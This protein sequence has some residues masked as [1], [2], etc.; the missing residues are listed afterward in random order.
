M[1]N[2]PHNLWAEIK[3]VFFE[4]FPEEAV[5]AIWG[6]KWRK[7][8]NIHPEPMFKFRISDGDRA[9]LLSNPPSLFLHSHP[10][11]SAEPSDQ[12]TLS[13]LATGWNWGIVAVKGNANG[14][15]YSV[16]YPECWGD[17][18]TPPPLLGRTFLWGVRDCWTLCRDWYAEQG[19]R[20]DN[21]PRARDPSIYPVGHWG[22]DPFNYWPTRV[23]FK[24]V[25]R[26]ERKPGDFAV[27]QFRSSKY[28]HCAI[29]Q[30]EGRFLHQI[31]D[32]TSSV[33][34]VADEDRLIERMNILFYRPK[35]A[36]RPNK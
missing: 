14:D 35:K 2:L 21:V 27:F 16:A 24:P 9:E 5:V 3:P 17:G 31:E 22:N 20:F 30:G 25:A 33:W 11:G 10:N 26:H 12:D 1:D 6:D 36:L 23:G 18:I 8:E 15:V 32:Q 7:L 13:Q 34:I 19:I 4:A 28:N 29:Y